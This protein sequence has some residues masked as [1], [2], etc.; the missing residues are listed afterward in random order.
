MIVFR[1]S[2]RSSAIPTAV[3]DE[4]R[5]TRSGPDVMLEWQRG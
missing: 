1:M 3:E 4:T 5:K 2:T